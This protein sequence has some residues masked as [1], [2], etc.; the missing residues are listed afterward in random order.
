MGADTDMIAVPRSLLACAAYCARKH[1]GADS[2]TYRALSK[3]SLTK[4]PTFAGMPVDELARGT[5]HPGDE[6]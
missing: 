4:V 1:A 3:A 5:W 2:T 6:A